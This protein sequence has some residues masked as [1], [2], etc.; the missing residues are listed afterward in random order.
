MC[1][2]GFDREQAKPG[3]GRVAP[4]SSA[5]TPGKQSL[6]DQQLGR[7][8]APQLQSPRFA[9]DPTLEACFED[10][11][12]LTVGAQGD[13][14][15]KVQQALLDL[16]FSVGNAGVDGIYGQAVWDAVK[17]FKTREK[18]GFENMGDVGPGTMHRL[19]A[20]FLDSISSPGEQAIEGGQPTALDFIVTND[21]GQVEPPEIPPELDEQ[22]ILAS[23]V[24]QPDRKRSMP[25]ALH[26]ARLGSAMPRRG[27]GRR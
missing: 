11:A 4:V 24:A 22:V 9:G 17:Q 23:F 3:A 14:V 25:C 15:R 1:R 7:G 2:M 5:P 13:S 8:G 16:G 10:R 19:D 12:R 21:D 18:L 6:V 27:H 20:L 26:P